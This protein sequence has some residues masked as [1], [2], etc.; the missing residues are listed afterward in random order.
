MTFPRAPEDVFSLSASLQSMQHAEHKQKSQM[1]L[2]RG[3]RMG[4]MQ[5]GPHTAQLK[6]V[7]FPTEKYK[8]KQNALH[9]QPPRAA[10][11]GQGTPAPLSP[12]PP[13]HQLGRLL[14]RGGTRGAPTFPPGT[15]H[16]VLSSQRHN[17][18]WRC[19]HCGSQR[20][21]LGPPRR[22]GSFSLLC[23]PKPSTPEVGTDPTPAAQ[24]RSGGRER[25]RPPA[26]APVSPSG[27]ANLCRL[28][29]QEQPFPA[30][31]APLPGLAPQ[32]PQ[33]P[34]AGLQRAPCGCYFDPR[35]FHFQWTT[36]SLPPP[37][38]A[39]LGHSAASV[40]GA[41]L[42][43]P[44]GC[45]TPLAW[46]LPGTPQGQ[47]QHLPPY[48][49]QGR[50]VAPAP[51]LLPTSIPGYQHIQG[52]SARI[53]TSGTA[54]SA[55]APAGSNIPLG[56]HVPPSPSAD[57]CNQALGDLEEELEVSEEMLLQEALRLF[58]CSSDTVG[59]SQ[60]GPSTDPMPG[61][62]AGTGGEGRAE[63][64]APTVL[65]M[66]IPGYQHREGHLARTNSSGTAT[67]MGATP[68]SNICP[69]SDVPSQGSQYSPGSSP[70]PG[71]PGHSSRDITHHDI[72]SLSLPEEL[73]TPDYSVPETSDSILSLD[74]FI[75]GMEPQEPWGDAGRDLPSSQ[76]AVSQKRGKKRGKSTLAAAPGKRRALAGS[77]GV[78]EGDEPNRR[79][80][81]Q[82]ADNVLA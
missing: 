52:Q 77:T 66:Y 2:P 65:P 41:A 46:A 42:W 25:R 36:T 78:A 76:P 80:S 17:G 26:M 7:L 63:A 75:M 29:G 58:E 60:D 74:K 32:P 18:P 10:S 45:G 3:T 56:S 79:A 38:T 4:Q 9:S 16:R 20:A 35:V 8:I 49:H 22:P 37:A 19:H 61:D 70:M 53:N 44:G 39:T 48:N 54:T 1:H 6:L 43:G 73:L 72:S 82:P 71:D 13:Q 67:P 64:P 40:P 11:R 59:V 68:G 57:P 27:S 28:P 69:G 30:A 51:P 12:F 34:P 50:V 62:P 14:G 21:A 47:P 5:L 81:E 55:G 23:S 15:R 33:A 31:W 24:G